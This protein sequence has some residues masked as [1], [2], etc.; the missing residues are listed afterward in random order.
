MTALAEQLSVAILGIRA[1]GINAKAH[2]DLLIMGW[3]MW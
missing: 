3:H 2:P 1:A